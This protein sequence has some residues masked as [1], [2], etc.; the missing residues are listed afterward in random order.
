MLT[1]TTR[2]QISANTIAPTAISTSCRVTWPGRISSQKTM[3]HS[4]AMYRL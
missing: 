4:G 1:V 3:A 2:I